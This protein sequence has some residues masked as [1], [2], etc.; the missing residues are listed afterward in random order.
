MLERRAEGAPVTLAYARQ[1]L[2]GAR[3]EGQWST[4]DVTLRRV[5]PALVALGR[6][7][8]AATVLG[9]LAAIE[10]T[11]YDEDLPQLEAA[12]ATLGVQLGPTSGDGGGAARSSTD[13]RTRWF[14]ACPNVAGRR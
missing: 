1:T 11:L 14:G 2:L 6:H 9:G 5:V 8:V 12:E 7:Q 10:S 4:I 13:R 3:D